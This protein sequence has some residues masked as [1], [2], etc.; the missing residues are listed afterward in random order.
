MSFVESIKPRLFSPWNHESFH[1]QTIQPNLNSILKMPKAQ[2]VHFPIGDVRYKNKP[3]SGYVVNPDGTQ[4][5]VEEHSGWRLRR[6][7]GGGGSNIRRIETQYQIVA[8]LTTSP[9]GNFSFLITGYTEEVRQAT[10]DDIVRGLTV[11]AEFPNSKLP[12]RIKNIRLD[13]IGRKYFV[14]INRPSDNNGNI[15]LTGRLSRS[16]SAYAEIMGKEIY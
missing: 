9:D 10:T 3:M 7:I 14:R 13:E 15:T 4:V 11:T 12:K 16:Q 6:I 5:N 1:K 8:R 2:Q